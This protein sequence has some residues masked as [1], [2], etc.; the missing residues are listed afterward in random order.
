[1]EEQRWCSTYSSCGMTRNHNLKFRSHIEKR[2]RTPNFL[3]WTK[4]LSS[5]CT[6]TDYFFLLCCFTVTLEIGDRFP[7][8]STFE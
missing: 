5:T 7:K 6:V 2:T 1:M 4:L 3:L 8:L